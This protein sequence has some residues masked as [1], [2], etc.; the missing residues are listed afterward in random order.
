MH[1]YNLAVKNSFITVPLKADRIESRINS[2]SLTSTHPRKIDS[3]K[4]VQL[5]SQEKKKSV[6]KI[7][8]K[9]WG[10]SA[11]LN[12]KLRASETLDKRILKCSVT[13]FLSLSIL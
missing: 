7:L 6:H 11:I 1:R 10:K 4:A 12:L 5:H 3:A 2:H 9:K 13:S 8:K